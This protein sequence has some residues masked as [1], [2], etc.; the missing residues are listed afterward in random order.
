VSMT[1][2]ERYDSLQRRHALMFSGAAAALLVLG[3]LFM[4]VQHALTRVVQGW[5]V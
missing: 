3:G 4:L 1:W 5:V 2:I